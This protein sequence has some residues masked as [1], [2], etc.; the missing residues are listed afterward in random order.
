MDPTT[1]G[2]VTVR[3]F[4][5]GDLARL[6]VDAGPRERHHH[7]ERS[8]MHERGEATYLVAWIGDLP[9]G[10]VTLFHRSKYETVRGT[11]GDFPEVN[12]LEATPRGHGIG[13]LLIS[14]AEERAGTLGAH[15]IGLAV[16]HSNRAAR[17][18]YGRRG[19]VD[20]EHGDVVDRWH[21]R[22][23]D[24]TVV[25]EHADLCSYLVKD[26]AGRPRG[27]PTHA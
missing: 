19:Y 7:E 13:S 2:T 20:W 21:E 11:A 1:A 3:P 25:G 16:A 14:A 5:P 26:L 4:H 23:G 6:L 10:R 8:R 18:L 24:G 9:C 17:R 15:R 22:D 27:G 12:A